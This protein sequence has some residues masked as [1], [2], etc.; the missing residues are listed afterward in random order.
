MSKLDF[1]KA[2]DD[3]AQ[4][5]EIVKTVPEALQQRCF[6]LLFDAVFS[7]VKPAAEPNAERQDAG[8]E[9]KPAAP[10]SKKLPPNV[11]AFLRR[12]KLEPEDLGKLFML[13][14]EPLL[15]VYKM[16]NGAIAKSQLTKVLM[17]I[18]ENGL[19][20]N[21]L[22]ATYAELRGSARDDGLFDGNFNKL[23]KRD[24]FKGVGKDGVTDDTIVE[25][26][27]TGMD[28]LAEVIKELG[29]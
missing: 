5:L 15:P 6:E 18:L 16:P 8:A 10:P 25:L 9:I 4:I 11:L 24:L 2:K 29:Q 20:N 1:A 13:D 26:S 14:H 7:K 21:S 28:K 19:L 23:F 17:V 3:I 27:G 22:S 12:Q